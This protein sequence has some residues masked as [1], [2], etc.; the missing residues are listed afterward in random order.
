MTIPT[1]SLGA[2]TDEVSAAL[3]DACTTVGF[4]YLKDHG[5]TDRLLREVLRQS[6]VLFALPD[7]QKRTLSDPTLERGHTRFGEETLDPAH[8][9]TRGDTKEGFYIREE[10]SA[11]DVSKLQGPNVWPTP[12]NCQLTDDQCRAFRKTMETYLSDATKV[13]LRLVRC[14]ALAVGSDP[15][16]FD[17]HFTKP[18]TTLRLLRYST[19]ASDQKAGLYACGAHSDYGMITLLLTDENPG[20]QVQSNDGNWMGIPPKRGAFVV[21]IGDMFERWTNGRF[22]STQHR[23]IT[24]KGAD[25]RYSVPFFFGPNFNA[26]VECLESCQDSEHPPRYP[27]ITA[28]QHLLDM[29]KKTHADFDYLG[30]KEV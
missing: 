24:P 13:C 11:M 5:I 14:F 17:R 1:I 22:K 2:P 12:T 15:C 4:F 26:L 23:V 29:Y 6:A 3:R 20:L 25:Q 10:A 27:P 21:N 19:E 9:P 7:D 30:E 28:G 16:V 8:Q 18:E